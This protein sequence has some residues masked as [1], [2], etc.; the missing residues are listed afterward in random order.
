MRCEKI[1]HQLSQI[2]IHR[3]DIRNAEYK[4]SCYV[5]LYNKE[6]RSL[7][8][9]KEIYLLVCRESWNKKD[10]KA[11]YEPVHVLYEDYKKRVCE[12][13]KHIKFLKQYIKKHQW[14]ISRM[15]LLK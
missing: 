6:L 3:D 9:I 4:L 1:K 14:C 10:V 2:E 11:I 12:Y 7:K 8:A 15:D 13:G 5:S